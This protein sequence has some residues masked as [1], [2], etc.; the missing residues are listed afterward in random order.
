MTTSDPE[1][2]LKAVNEKDMQAW[3]VVFNHF[4]AALCSYS[5]HFVQ[6]ADA[7]E[8]IVQDVMMNIWKGRHAFEDVDSLSLYFYRATYRQS[9]MHLRN[10]QLRAGH[11]QDA[12]LEQMEWS[13]E[14]FAATVR[15]ELIRQLHMCI[16]ELPAERKKVVLLSIE[17]Y[18][19]SEI[20]DQLGI[21]V[22][23]VKVQ[24][25]RSYKYLRERIQY[26]TLCLLLA[27]AT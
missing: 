13:E 27:V 15:E 18:S 1:I 14:D 9:L 5:Q 25:Y 7:A 21:S 2:I 26:S 6:D 20:A 4:Y 24:K 3:N 19:N 22:N 12:F 10:K 11:L 16:D 17:G 8:D 23:T